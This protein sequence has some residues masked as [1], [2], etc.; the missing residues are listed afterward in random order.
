MTEQLILKQQPIE[1][2]RDKYLKELQSNSVCS[3]ESEAVFAN[4]KTP[5]PKFLYEDCLAQIKSNQKNIHIAKHF[6]AMVALRL[7]CWLR[8]RYTC[9]LLIANSRVIFI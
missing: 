6:L 1:K 8:K 9:T 2:G 7:I 3:D 5:V 4:S